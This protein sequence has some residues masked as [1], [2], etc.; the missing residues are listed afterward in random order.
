MKVSNAFSK[1]AIFSSVVKVLRGVAAS[2]SVILVWAVVVEVMY[3]F[4]TGEYTERV[5]TRKIL[6]NSF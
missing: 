1:S 2:H 5:Q 3:T 6:W 4:Y